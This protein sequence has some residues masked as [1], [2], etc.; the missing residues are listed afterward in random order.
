ML[1]QRVTFPNG[2]KTYVDLDT[3][4]PVKEF[5]D[6]IIN[7]FITNLK[8]DEFKGVLD[9]VSDF[10]LKVYNHNFIVIR[11]EDLSKTFEELGFT[12]REI[13]REPIYIISK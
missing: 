9:G 11:D 8:N 10:Y 12:R 13:Y 1:K 5:K 4:K 2:K 3:E 6:R 7:D